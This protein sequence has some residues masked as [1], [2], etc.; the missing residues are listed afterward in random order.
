[1]VSKYIVAQQRRMRDTDGPQPAPPA[2]TTE[3]EPAQQ[4]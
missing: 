1:M 4:R 3:G 2:T